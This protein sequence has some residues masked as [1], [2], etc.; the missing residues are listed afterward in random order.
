MH[1]HHC[2]F[3]HEYVRKLMQIL[4]G[5]WIAPGGA[6]RIRK[7]CEVLARATSQSGRF[8]YGFRTKLYFAVVEKSVIEDRRGGYGVLHY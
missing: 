7:Y 5:L 2:R 6:Q 4:S 8:A 3:L 1:L